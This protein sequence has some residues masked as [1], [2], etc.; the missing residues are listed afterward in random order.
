LSPRNTSDSNE[1][2]EDEGMEFVEGVAYTRQR[3][4]DPRNREIF[5]LADALQGA[6][7]ISVHC[8]DGKT[9]MGRI[10]GK[11]KKRQWIRPGD[12]L[13]V[14][15][16]DFQDDKCDV[17]FRYTRTQAAQLARRKLLPESMNVF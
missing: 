16:W 5:A 9:R 12:L 3:L 2:F 14:K 4:P 1:A 13:I 7:R 10:P 17:K 15:P 8:Q 6:S 11:M